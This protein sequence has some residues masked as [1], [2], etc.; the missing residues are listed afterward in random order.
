MISLFS[1]KVG[2]QL[3]IASTVSNLRQV[4]QTKQSLGIDRSRMCKGCKIWITEGSESGEIK[5]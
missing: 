2:D 1:F 3:G 5:S 4:S